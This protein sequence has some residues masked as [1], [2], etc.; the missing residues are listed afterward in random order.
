VTRLP[1]VKGVELVVASVVTGPGQRAATVGFARCADLAVLLEHPIKG[2]V[3]GVPY[4]LVPTSGVSPGS[5]P[6]SGTIFRFPLETRGHGRSFPEAVPERTL[7]LSFEDYI[8]LGTGI[9]LP[10]SQLPGGEIPSSAQIDL[11]SDTS[12]QAID[13]VTA[14]I[15]R[16]AP[17][18]QVGFPNDDLEMRRHSQIFQSL[19]NAALFLGV[20]IGLCA[21]VVAVLDRAVERRANVVSLEIVGVPI[22]ALRAAQAAQ[23]A[24][25]LAI[26][27]VI[28]ILAGK[29]AEQVT[30]SVGGYVRSW[31]WGG[32][33]LA[34]AVGLVAALIA[35]LATLPAVSS[36]IDVSLIRRE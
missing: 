31:T 7:R 22:T 13:S 8:N 32:S 17:L 6:Q 1:S 27:T 33:L 30:V 25:P 29:L 15:A 18:A 4:H 14:G 5:V 9:L 12:A 23:V 34:L 24:L 26:G 2:C 16:L 3:E 36:R 20:V 28:A 21:F 19:L 35:I 11:A 10:P